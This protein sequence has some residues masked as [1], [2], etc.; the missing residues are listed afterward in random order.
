MQLGHGTSLE[1]V[2]QFSFIDI[3]INDIKSDN[4][5]I[6]GTYGFDVK[7]TYEI[8]DN[9]KK[10]IALFSMNNPEIKKLSDYFVPKP[11]KK[12]D[13]SKVVNDIRI[14]LR[15]IKKLPMV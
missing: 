4:I 2:D 7:S 3:F 5:D 13:I 10:D 9:I 11:F 15:Q 8:I 12:S 1:I 14:T 6:N